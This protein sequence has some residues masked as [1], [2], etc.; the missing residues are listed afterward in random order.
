[1]NVGFLE[2]SGLRTSTNN[3]PHVFAGWLFIVTPNV[4]REE[5]QE[6]PATGLDNHT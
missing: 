3:T 2:V 1:M 4:F 6:I 5:T